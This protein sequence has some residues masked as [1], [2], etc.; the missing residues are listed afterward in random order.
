MCSHIFHLTPC[1]GCLY[2]KSCDVLWWEQSCSCFVRGQRHW[3]LRPAEEA[4]L[5]LLLGLGLGLGL[6][7]IH[8][9]SVVRLVRVVE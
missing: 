3:L 8:L 7:P 9:V 4:K 1:L 5:Y 2:Y 6:G